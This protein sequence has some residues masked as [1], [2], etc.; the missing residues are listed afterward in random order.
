MRHDFSLADDRASV[1]RICQLV[2]GMPLALELAASWT[3]TI[4]CAAIADEIGRN[5]DFLATSLRD[6]PEQHRSIRAVFDHSWS[7]LSQQEQQVF[8]RLSVFRGGFRREAAEQVV[9]ASLAIL[10]ALVD[11]SLIRW[12]PDGRYHIHELLRQYAE[13][14]LHASPE[15]STKM[16]DAHCAYYAR[17]LKQRRASIEDGR[18]REVIVEIAADVDNLRAAWQW[19]VAHANVAEMHKS[20]TTLDLFFQ[21]RS[22]YVEAR[23]AFEGAVQS[24]QQASPSD[25]H[26]Q[27]RAEILVCLGWYCLRL[28][29]FE[30]AR[31]CFEESQALFHRHGIPHPAGNGTDPLSGLGTLANI[32]GKYAE[33]EQ[34]GEESRR[35]NEARGDRQNLMT[36]WYVLANAAFAQGQYQ[37]A[38]DRAQ[39]A[40]AIAQTLN[41]RWTMAYYLNDLGNVAQTLK[42]YDRARQYYQA[43]YDL[44]KEFDDPEGMAVALR[45]LGEIAWLRQEYQA[46]EGLYQQSLAIYR[47]IGDRGGLATTLMG[48][49][50]AACASGDYH[51]AQRHLQEA[52]RITTTIQFVPLTLAVLVAVGELLLHTRRA[53]V[54]AEL[55]AFAQQHPASN[56]QTKARAQH[57]L[58][59]V[60]RPAT[61]VGA[62]IQRGKHS[63]LEAVIA[64]AQTHL[65]MPAAT[66]ASQSTSA[67]ALA[68]PLTDREMEVL[69]LMAEG[70]SNPEIAQRLVLATGTVK[71]YTAAIYSKLGVRNRVQAVERGHALQ[72][73]QH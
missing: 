25:L 18:Q 60:D 19:M 50:Q 27:T 23:E 24:L 58:A 71:Y 53:A 41:D 35:I 10:S 47:H 61:Q 22:H 11:K 64:V 40:Y 63:D 42:D 46:A 54:A 16:R 15:D 7:L 34:L 26:D 38:Q 39:R 43:A 62:A 29:Q 2:E 28:G 12:S 32:Q 8:K 51:A 3:K 56:Q 36:S 48:L 49:G 31:A 37:A 65:A 68:E 9:G 17:F 57:L 70:L 30:R 13:E 21:M 5:L 44:R 52:L 73:L 59:A 20:L 69:R 67:A 45:H 14:Q 6:M 66:P 33:A 72:L 1:T 4:P 55:L